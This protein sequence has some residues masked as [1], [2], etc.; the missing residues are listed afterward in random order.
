MGWKPGFVELSLLEFEMRNVEMVLAAADQGRRIDKLKPLV[1]SLDA[2]R[3]LLY[4][5]QDVMD[6]L[7][8]YRLQQ[9]IEKEKENREGET[10]HG[11]MLPPEVKLGISNRI[12]GIVNN[13]QRTGNSVRG[14]L[15]PYI[16]HLALPSTQ[17]QSETRNTRL[18]TSVPHE[19]KVF[20]RD[21]D[22]DRIL[23]ILLDDGSS[24]LRVLPIVGI[25][26]I[27][28]TTLTKFV[29]RDQRVVDYF[30]LRIWVCVSTYFNKVAITLEI[31]EHICK[32]KQEYK[33]VSNFNVLQEI[34]MKNIREKI[35]ARVG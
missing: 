25:G 31:L 15:L 20:G 30:D 24:D 16:S 17:R 5:A 3:E 34:L 26:G 29:Y 1:H 6:E 8:Y 4:D 2:L 28:K 23:K 12:N 9:Q 14:I 18:T 27:G 13:L 19:L 22:R 21:A 10:A 32:D 7:D 33:D 35:S 11:T